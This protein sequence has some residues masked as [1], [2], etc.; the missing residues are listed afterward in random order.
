MSSRIEDIEVF[1]LGKCSGSIYPTCSI[2][3]YDAVYGVSPPIAKKIKR[4][5]TSDKGSF[6][7]INDNYIPYSPLAS[8]KRHIEEVKK[9]SLE[10]EERISKFCDNNKILINGNKS[11]KNIHFTRFEI[12]DI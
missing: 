8:C 12:M 9:M 1:E 6:L 3:D 11:E 2:C 7:V 10:D 4:F 5:V